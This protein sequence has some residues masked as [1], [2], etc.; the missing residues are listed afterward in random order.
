MKLIKLLAT[1][2]IICSL[3]GCV[4]QIPPKTDGTITTIDINSISNVIANDATN[5]FASE[6]P[7][8]KTRFNINQNI[9]RDDFFG[10]TFIDLMRKKGFE[11]QEN[12]K[13]STYNNTKFILDNN[14]SFVRLLITIDDSTYA[15]CYSKTT[16][17][18][19]SSWTVIKRGE[20]K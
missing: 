3:S 20:N 1:V 10:I 12:A 18:S 15:K 6:F 16:G 7:P 4:S 13:D 5:F 19:M 17:K 9:A 8:A 14:D 2:F 11:I